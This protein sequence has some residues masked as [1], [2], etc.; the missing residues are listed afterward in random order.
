MTQ[1]QTPPNIDPIWK[2]FGNTFQFV[3]SYNDNEQTIAVWDVNFNLTYFFGNGFLHKNPI[4]QYSKRQ[5]MVKKHVNAVTMI[6][7]SMRN[8]L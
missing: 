2:V 1:R 3:D 6:R 4:F 5:M 8:K 7:L